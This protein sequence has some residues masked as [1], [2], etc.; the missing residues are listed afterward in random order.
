VRCAI[1]GN[2][3]VFILPTPGQAQRLFAAHDQTSEDDLPGLEASIGAF[4]GA[5]WDDEEWELE[6][7][8]AD[9]A[10]VFVEL[11]RFGWGM[12]VCSA[13]MREL[14]RLMGEDFIAE[15]EVQRRVRFFGGK[16]SSGSS[17]SALDSNTSETPGGGTG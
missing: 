3:Y 6:S 12:Q 10:A 5:C 14:A 7:D 13:A 17:K 8:P 4:L 16:E 9:G 2:P 1:D 15:E 11:H